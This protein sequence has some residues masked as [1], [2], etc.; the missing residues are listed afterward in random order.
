MGLRISPNS[1]WNSYKMGSWE[2]RFTG[3]CI[4]RLPKIEKTKTTSFNSM[5]HA[6]WLM[7]QNVNLLLLHVN[8]K[9]ISKN[10]RRQHLKNPLNLIYFPLI[11]S[12][13]LVTEIINN[14]MLLRKL[15]L[16]VKKINSSKLQIWCFRNLLHTNL[17]SIQKT[18]TLAFFILPPNILLNCKFLEDGKKLTEK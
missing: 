2:V 15:T 3:G 9:W 8:Q 18:T 4:L 7:G 13:N 10:L 16:S 5:G 11:Q 6:M 1:L 17:L 14:R 12:Y